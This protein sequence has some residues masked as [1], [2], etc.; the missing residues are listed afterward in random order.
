MLERE[1]EREEENPW[2]VCC[3]L[4]LCFCAAH[5]KGSQGRSDKKGQFPRRCPG[6]QTCSTCWICGWRG[7]V[8]IKFKEGAFYFFYSADF[9][10]EED[11]FIFSANCFVWLGDWFPLHFLHSLTVNSADFTAIWVS[12]YCNCI[13]NLWTYVIVVQWLFACGKAVDWKMW[14]SERIREVN[15]DY[16][17][18]TGWV[19][20]PT[21]LHSCLFSLEYEEIDLKEIW[22]TIVLFSGRIPVCGLCF[23]LYREFRIIP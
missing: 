22:K 17:I 4:W 19:L 16:K 12:L 14:N 3:S 5:H 21:S 7:R 15:K 20:L 9:L 11:F 8:K 18:Q 2:V 10:P 23:C 6:Q 13:Y 1:R